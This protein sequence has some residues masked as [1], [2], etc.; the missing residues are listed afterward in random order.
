MNGDLNM[1]NNAKTRMKPQTSFLHKKQCR[2]WIE[3]GFTRQSDFDDIIFKLSRYFWHGDT[4]MA[5]LFG[6][7]QRRAERIFA[8]FR[9]N[10]VLSLQEE[11]AL[12]RQIVQKCISRKNVKKRREKN[13]HRYLPG[14]GMN[15][16]NV[17]TSNDAR[18]RIAKTINELI[19]KLHTQPS[20]NQICKSARSSR[21]TVKKYFEE[22]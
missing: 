3:H 18:E 8:L 22:I 13:W 10:I 6:D 12:W 2:L 21:A 19:E 20:I 4:H 5:G 14:S 15:D 16:S 11:Q 17:K 9:E 7:D 1:L